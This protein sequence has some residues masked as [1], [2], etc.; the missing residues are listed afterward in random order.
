M[1]SFRM[2]SSIFLHSVLKI[3]PFKGRCVHKYK[4]TLLVTSPTLEKWDVKYET[5]QEDE[6]SKNNL[7]FLHFRRSLNFPFN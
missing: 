4:I 5:V 6:L 2:A 3:F 7:E 1:I